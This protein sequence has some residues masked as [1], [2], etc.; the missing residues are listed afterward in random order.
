LPPPTDD[1]DPQLWERLQELSGKAVAEAAEK[2]AGFTEDEE[3]MHK[4]YSK[5]LSRRTFSKIRTIFYW[6]LLVGV[7]SVLAICAAAYLYLVWLW[8]GTVIYGTTIHDAAGLKSF[9]DG[10][11]WSILIIFATLFFEGAFK[12]RDS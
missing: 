4:R 3:A 6:F 8:L 5:A 10:V 2:S 1:G 9:I 12:E 11:L 7:C